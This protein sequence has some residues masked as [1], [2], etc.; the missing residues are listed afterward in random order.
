MNLEIR[1]LQYEKMRLL[2]W[3]SL[4]AELH[5]TDAEEWALPTVGSLVYSW[6]V[7][8]ADRGKNFDDHRIL[9]GLC[10]MFDI[11]GY[12]PAVA[13]FGFDNLAGDIESELAGNHDAGLLMQM[14]VGRDCSAFGNSEFAHQCLFTIDQG[15]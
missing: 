9:Q 4:P 5:L 14:G 13:G 8:F 10:G 1:T 15:G 7:V 6:Q 11:A 3:N 2:I 12:A